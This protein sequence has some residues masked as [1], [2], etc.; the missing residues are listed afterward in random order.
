MDARL[1]TVGEVLVHRFRQRGDE[2]LAEVTSV[3]WK[4]RTVR[5]RVG[6]REYATLSAA[7]KAISGGSQNGWVY[8]GSR[9]RLLGVAAG[10]KG[11]WLSK[12]C[13]VSN[14]RESF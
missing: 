1:P 10:K 8:W 9:N 14:E 13:G 3:D 6:E 4:S 2:V 11:W 7:A 12:G 5:V